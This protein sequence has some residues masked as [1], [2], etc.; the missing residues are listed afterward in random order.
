MCLCAKLHISCRN[1]VETPA[2][3]P[4]EVY[5]F[6]ASFSFPELSLTSHPDLPIL[7]NVLPD[8]VTAHKVRVSRLKAF[9]G[10]ER[11]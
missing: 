9:V 11:T 3:F 4:V 8:H 2:V 10:A 6:R 5:Q 1:L 7:A